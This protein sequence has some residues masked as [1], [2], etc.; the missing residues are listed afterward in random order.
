MHVFR[1]IACFL[2]LAINLFS[3]ATST[4][5]DIRGAILDPSG[6]SIA[7]ARVTASN[8]ERGFTRSTVSTAEGRFTIASIPPGIY[9]VRTEASGFTTKVVESLEVR[10]GDVI[11]LL[12]QLPI[13]TVESEVVVIADIAAVEVERTQQ[14]NTIEQ[15]R[16]NNLP[17]NRR[18]YLDFAL[19][20]P[21]VV[22]TTSLVDDSS[23][24]PIQTPNSGLSFGGSNGRGNGFFIDGLENFSNAGG[25]VRPSISQEAAQEF[26]INR[27][28]YSAEFGN[29]F[30][31]VINVISK[32]GSNQLHGNAFG[33]FR[34]KNIQ[35][36][37]YFDPGK[38]AFTRVQAGATLGGA[39][40]RDRT[41]FYSAYE[42]LSRQETSF[43]PI[44]Q[45][46]GVFNRITPSQDQLFRFLEASG[47]PTLAGLAGQGRVM[48]QPR[49][50]PFLTNLFNANSGAFPFSQSL[51]TFSLR[52]D[53]K[54]S[55]KNTAFFRSNST[56]DRQDNTSFGALDGFNRGR[57]L[58]IG[59][60]TAAIGDTWS[61][62]SNWVVE[63]RGMFGYNRFDVYP[64]DK[65]GPEININGF[66]LFG[67]QI[68]LPGSNI[69]RHYQ[70]I[71]NV[72]RSSGRHTLKFGY[73]FNPVR[74]NAVN[75]TFLGGRFT[76]GSRIPLANV[77]IAATGNPALPELISQILAGA[78]QP[79]L[80]ANLDT[81]VSALQS[82]ALGIPQLY[83]QGF[84]DPAYVNTTYNN[85]LYLQDSF[86]L[87][88]NLTL[89]AGLRYEVQQQT[90]EMVP[91]DYNNLAP[92]IGFA[93]SP[94]KSQSL[95]I[96]GGYGIY[97]SMIN[98]NVAGTAAPLSG[99]KIN[100]ILLTTSST[101]FLDPRNGQ[102]VTSTTIFQ[103]MLAQGILGKRT[104]GQEDLR[105]FGISVGPN[106][107]GSVIFGVDKDYVNPYA[108]QGSFEVE[109]QI[110]GFAVSI[111]YNFNRGTHIGRI[112]GRNVRYS[113]ARLPD[114]RPLFER[115][116]PLILQNNVF[117]SSANS[118]YHAG[119]LQA[120]RRF[121][122][123]FTFNFNYT[124]SKAIDESIDFNSDYSP[125]DQ[126][127]ARAERS[128]SSFH[129]KH[130][131]V[132]NS[133][134]ERWGW[135]FA[136]IVLYN[137]W[138]PFNVLAGVDAQG[139]TYVSNKRPAHLGRNM[140]QGPNFVTADLR[141]SRRFRYSTNER[142]FLEWTAE[143]FNLLN[144]TNFRTIN[145][146][147]GDVPYATL[148]APIIGNRN[149]ASTPL[150]FTSTQNQRQ[151][152]L[153]L[154]LYF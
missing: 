40:K 42:L 21:G 19:L 144:R 79:G 116:N 13:S 113:G 132:F 62:N 1:S 141:I 120:S 88:R 147:V 136:P 29:A 140:G 53:H 12:I 68:F 55:D 81:P 135:N 134:I 138:R 95:V 16:I 94:G 123:G 98:N 143:A 45:D 33:F 83:Q 92:R 58:N 101:L 70:A 71:V 39:I 27:N 2:P 22:E 103:S 137:S 41:F 78:G 154:K 73:D 66:G 145:N 105:P 56:F 28:S 93:W 96:R 85:N 59:D 9:K 50:S 152:Q 122:K 10:V 15:A 61:P 54:F 60:T 118:F 114:G 125:Q 77:L 31:G 38:S 14:S 8:D 139:D 148:G 57:Q 6:N 75:E 90:E 127:N 20:A 107:P 86:K 3:Q 100:Q 30:G 111:A 76:F 65:L 52:L 46:R 7:A 97:Y 11:S 133:V 49:S 80:I 128:L 25:G 17:I 99:K 129:Q 26:Q 34:H 67:R 48:L 109:R 72:R 5:G 51:N 126:L 150:A 23:Y 102:F 89:T 142:R 104:I 37:N 112:R 87:T 91:R 18:N 74:N 43:I 124:L 131:I 64:I 82:A 47:N 69:E 44:L 119:I 108:Q 36:R 24:R 4:S 149:P 32:S 115:I 153:G 84:G 146:V 121:S 117:E 110:A 106:L 35:A 63:S 130:R 151:F